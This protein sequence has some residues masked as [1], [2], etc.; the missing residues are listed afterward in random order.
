[1]R[2]RGI[3]VARRCRRRRRIEKQGCKVI[4]A[5]TPDAIRIFN[6]SKK[7]KV[8]PYDLLIPRKLLITFW[9]SPV[10]VMPL[11]H[12]QARDHDPLRLFDPYRPAAPPLP[13]RPLADRALQPDDVPQA[14][15]GRAAEPAE[16]VQR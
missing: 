9:A 10:S 11:Q 3:P 13:H 14:R 15:A 2:S 8:L 1:M 7:A 16:S 4:A 5:P 6:K 12:A